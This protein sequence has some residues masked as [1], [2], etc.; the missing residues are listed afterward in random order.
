MSLY[1]LYQSSLTASLG[2]TWFRKNFD[3]SPANN[4]VLSTWRPEEK[5]GRAWG[6]EMEVLEQQVMEKGSLQLS[7]YGAE[8][9]QLWKGCYLS[10]ARTSL[11]ESVS[12]IKAFFH[13]KIFFFLIRVTGTV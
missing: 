3:Y 13:S 12:E 5:R 7:Q 1:G 6:P 10:W 4:V 8:R 2:N 11:T 9:Q